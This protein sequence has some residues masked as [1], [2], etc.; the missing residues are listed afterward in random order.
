MYGAL[1]KEA[2]VSVSKDSSG[3]IAKVLDVMR[4]CGDRVSVLH[5]NHMEMLPAYLMGAAH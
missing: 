3:D 5:G 2:R 1:V 4:V